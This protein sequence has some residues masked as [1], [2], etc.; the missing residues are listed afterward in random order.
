MFIRVKGDPMNKQ[1]RII[2]VTSLALLGILCISSGIMY[3]N[4]KEN[5]VDN[6][7]LIVVEQKQISKKEDIDIKLKNLTIEVNTPL[8]VKIID[9]LDSAVSDEVLANLKLDTSS[10][11]VTEPGTYNYTVKYKKKTYKGII[12]VKEKEVETNALQSI[13]LRTLN[14][15]IGTALNTDLST[16]I[17]EPLNDEQKNSMVLDL[18]SVNVNKAGTYQ[19]TVKFNNSIYTGNIIITEDQ[20]TLSTNITNNQPPQEN[21]Q[22]NQTTNSNNETETN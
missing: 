1:V 5:N 16:Y 18:S 19:Y 12:I 7:I 14:I 17:I 3:S 10:V 21:E 22:N 8:S 13:T 4:L 15:K 11:N 9:Y 2:T 20:P 6:K